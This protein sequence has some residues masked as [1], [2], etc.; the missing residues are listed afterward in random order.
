MNLKPGLNE[1]G[2]QGTLCHVNFELSILCL[3]WNLNRPYLF[4][5]AFPLQRTRHV[6][7]DSGSQASGDS[8]KQDGRPHG[9]MGQ[10]KVTKCKV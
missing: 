5:C 1:E 4:V 9:G 3:I 6:G 7:Q 10:I 2:R 8:C